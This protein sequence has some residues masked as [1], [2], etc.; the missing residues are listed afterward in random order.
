MSP[1]GTCRTILLDIVPKKEW[2]RASPGPTEPLFR[3]CIMER[4]EPTPPWPAK[5][6]CMGTELRTLSPSIGSPPPAGTRLGP[7]QS[8]LLY[9]RQGQSFVPLSSSC[10][11]GERRWH[12]PT[13]IAFTPMLPLLFCRR[14][15]A[16]PHLSFSTHFNYLRLASGPSTLPR[17][18]SSLILLRARRRRLTLVTISGR[19]D[20]S[21]RPL[22]LCQSPEILDCAG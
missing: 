3:L 12:K 7:W 8:R 19:S 2:F 9:L 10:A 15:S 16:P 14:I 18:G 6:R 22:K 11:T 5:Y 1:F 13:V 4:R 20:W 17:A 21:P